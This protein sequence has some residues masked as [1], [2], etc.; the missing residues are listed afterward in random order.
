MFPAAGLNPRSP[1]GIFGYVL[2]IEV[3]GSSARVFYGE[4]GERCVALL[5]K[6]FLDVQG[7]VTLM[8]WR[9]Q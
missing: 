5:N 1:A 2:R 7:T 6:N 4:Q 8:M 9:L 3:R